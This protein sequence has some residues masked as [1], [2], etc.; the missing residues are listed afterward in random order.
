[1]AL[2]YLSKFNVQTMFWRHSIGVIGI[3]I[4]LTCW[5]ICKTVCAGSA[6]E[7][8]DVKN[9]VAGK[10]ILER[11]SL[12]ELIFQKSCSCGSYIFNELLQVSLNFA[13]VGRSTQHV[14]AW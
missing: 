11:Q 5:H 2:W 4:L 14:V 8:Q 9:N 6:A 13:F 1:M 3:N 10:S 12:F 7:M